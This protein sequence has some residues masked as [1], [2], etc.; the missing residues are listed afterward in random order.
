MVVCVITYILPAAL[1]FTRRVN[2]AR[3]DGLRQ[4]CLQSTLAIRRGGR[5]GEAARFLASLRRLAGRERRD[6]F[7]KGELQVRGCGWRL[8]ES[9]RLPFR[10]AGCG[11]IR[12]CDGT[13]AQA[14]S[15][16]AAGA[17]RWVS[18][19]KGSMR[20][21]PCECFAPVISTPSI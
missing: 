4:G 18:V 17:T 9:N 20:V 16:H 8:H 14:T 13:Q 6:T 19:S 7:D 1:C 10:L 11:S 5:A 21:I 12:K 2:G 15:R 3:R